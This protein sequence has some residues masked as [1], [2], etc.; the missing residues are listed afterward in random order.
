MVDLYKQKPKEEDLDDIF[1]DKLKAITGHIEDYAKKLDEKV[2]Y[3]RDPAIKVT[4]KYKVNKP[5]I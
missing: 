4:T 3:K 5:L 1:G 2:E